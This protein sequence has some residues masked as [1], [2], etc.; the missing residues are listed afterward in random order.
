MSCIDPVSDLITRIRNAQMA[1]LDIME[2]PASKM[3]E[4]VLKVMLEEGYIKGYTVVQKNGLNYLN[5]ELK[6]YDGAPVISHI[7]RISKPGRRVYCK[8]DRIAQVCNGLGI[9]ILS[10]NRGVMSDIEAKKLGIGGELLCS[11][12]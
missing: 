10:T 11:V 5:V 6:Y 3:R 7:K 1:G 8:V 12:F 4:S 9:S 2:T